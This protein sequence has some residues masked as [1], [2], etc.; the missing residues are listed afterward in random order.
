MRFCSASEASGFSDQA[1][2]CKN[3]HNAYLDDGD[4]N[5]DG[6]DVVNQQEQTFVGSVPYDCIDES[7]HLRQLYLWDPLKD[8]IRLVLGKE[9]LY[10]FC[11]HASDIG[12]H[13]IM[14]ALY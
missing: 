6:D 13:E 10:R 14:Q 11:S 5:S 9:R 7:T 1:F 3:T 2:F 12:L 4:S 8:F